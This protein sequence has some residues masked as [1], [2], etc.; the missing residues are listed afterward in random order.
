MKD[1]KPQLAMYFQ[2]FSDMT[3]EERDEIQHALTFMHT[4]VQYHSDI[5][6]NAAA[7]S[8]EQKGSMYG[9][10]WCGA[11]TYSMTLTFLV[12]LIL[13]ITYCLLYRGSIWLIFSRHE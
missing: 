4:D 8:A 5:K 2:P 12:L 13:Y 7:N 3:L 10:G 1:N 9:I 11:T 6:T